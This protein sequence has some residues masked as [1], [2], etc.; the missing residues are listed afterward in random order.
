MEKEHLGAAKVTTVFPHLMPKPHHKAHTTHHRDGGL[1]DLPRFPVVHG[2]PE[3]THESHQH[4]DHDNH[5]LNQPHLLPKPD[6]L[7][8]R[9]KSL[10]CLICNDYTG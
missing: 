3:K 6:H 9:K 7:K 2:Q 10:K 4:Q 5:H 8:V 1:H